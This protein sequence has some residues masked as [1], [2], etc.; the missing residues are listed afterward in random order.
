MN[1]LSKEFQQGY[2]DYYAG[3]DLPPYDYNTHHIEWADWC[4]G[5]SKAY[6]EDESK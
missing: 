3:I 5:H 2:E 6:C 1:K 4:D